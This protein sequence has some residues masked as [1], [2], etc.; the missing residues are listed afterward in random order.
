MRYSPA[1][2]VIRPI[3]FLMEYLLKAAA[4]LAAL[5]T[6]AAPGSFPEKLATGFG[7]LG[8]AVRRVVAWPDQAA[9]LARVIEDYNT[10]TA[11][12]FNQRYGG[13]ALNQVMAHLNRAVDFGQA[14]YGNVS[15]QPVATVSAVLLAFLACWISARGCRFVRQRGQGSWLTRRE[16]KWGDRVFEKD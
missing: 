9:W 3:L 16:R 11:A 14:V 8:E 2:M 15:L 13:E 6:L 4:G 12:A 7:S 5:I 10:L 1:D